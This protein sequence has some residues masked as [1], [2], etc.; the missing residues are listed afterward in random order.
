MTMR[1]LL[2][3]A[4][5]GMVTLALAATASARPWAV[6]TT[7]G[8]KLGF[9]APGF[10]TATGVVTVNASNAGKH[11]DILRLAPTDRDAEIQLELPRPAIERFSRTQK[12]P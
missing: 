8:T 3:F 5:V 10:A 9:G 1:K 6:T 4:L 12:K 11:L 2:S 7:L